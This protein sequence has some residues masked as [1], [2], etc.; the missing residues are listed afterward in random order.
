MQKNNHVAA[1]VTRSLL[2]LRVLRRVTHVAF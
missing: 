1:K 2:E